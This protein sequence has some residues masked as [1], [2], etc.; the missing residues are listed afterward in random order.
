MAGE[1]IPFGKYKGQPLEVM[2]QDKQYVDWLTAQPWFRERFQNIYTLVVNNF[3]EPTE[4]PE[5]NKLQALFLDGVFRERF[6]R[7]V[8]LDLPEQFVTEVQFEHQNFDVWVRA[9]WKED[10]VEK[11]GFKWVETICRDCHV[12]IKPS[13][14]DD[15]PAV[16]RQIKAAR[17]Y[18]ASEFYGSRTHRE[19][20][21]AACPVLFLSEYQGSGATEQQFIDI[22]EAEGIKVVFLDEVS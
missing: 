6:Q 10:R 19:Q 22:F 16:L 17:V 5:H 11:D 14:A 20:H 2:S 13:V 1:I 15:Y 21:V 9:S 3:Q 7:F 12:E 18:V 8:Y 4:T